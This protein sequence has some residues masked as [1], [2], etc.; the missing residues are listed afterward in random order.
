[1]RI[2]I[3]IENEEWSNRIR[4]RGIRETAREASLD[5]GYLSKMV[6]NQ[7]IATE[8]MMER[9]RVATNNLK[10]KYPSK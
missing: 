5:Y 9:L 2:R 7:V 3:I 10:P 8:K 4:R 6:N 1:M